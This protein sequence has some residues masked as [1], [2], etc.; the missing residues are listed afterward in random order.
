[1]EQS[2]AKRDLTPTHTHTPSFSGH[3]D[4]FPVL[5]QG[6]D[7]AS[8]MPPE[9]GDSLASDPVGRTK[10]ITSEPRKGS[11]RHGCLDVSPTLPEVPVTVVTQEPRYFL[12][13]SGILE[14]FF[15]WLSGPHG[16]ESEV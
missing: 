16:A 7:G 11:A 2:L 15:L 8:R 13:E 4:L 9:T 10:I 14:I 5:S 1:M 12:E 6:S 3:H